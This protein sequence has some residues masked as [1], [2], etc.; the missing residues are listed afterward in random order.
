MITLVAAV[1]R[2][3]AIGRD[4]AMPWRLPED[5]AHF[6]AVTNGHP[7]VMGRATFESIGRPLPGRTSIVVT[8][9]PGWTHD[10]VEVAHS[11]E[12]ALTRA[13]QLDGEAMV[14]GGGAVYAATIDRADRLEITHVDLTI[15]RPDTWFPPI[16]PAAWQVVAVRQGAS[17]AVSLRWTTYTRL[18]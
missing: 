1:D 17:G 8:R 18:G 4:N 3:L 12:D 7:L 16:D 13:A 9:D 5:L 11:I 2:H 6:K 10:G 15:D 14:I